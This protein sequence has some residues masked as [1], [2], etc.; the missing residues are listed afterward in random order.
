MIG[1]ADPKLWNLGVGILSKWNGLTLLFFFL[2]KKK[3]IFV[4]G[5]S[6][7]LVCPN[8]LIRIFFFTPR[9]SSSARLGQN[10]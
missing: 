3:N 5:G 9:N 4:N 8:L 7:N 10:S 6:I 1:L 2:L